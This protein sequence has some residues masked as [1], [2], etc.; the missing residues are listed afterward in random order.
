MP[1]LD[2]EA[3]IIASAVESAQ[4]SLIAATVASCTCGAE[5]LSLGLHEGHCRTL[6]I[7]NALDQLDT[8]AATIAPL[9]EE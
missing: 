9:T 5:S 7:A 1:I 3:S 4:M 8:I 6:K 2:P